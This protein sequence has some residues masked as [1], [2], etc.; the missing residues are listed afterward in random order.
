M[1]VDHLKDL[2][3]IDA[4]LRETLRL[5]PTVPAFSRSI[6]NDNPND[7]EPLLGGQY[8]ARRDDK[9]L[10]LVSKAQRDPKVYGEDAN[11]FRPERM[12]EENFQRLPKAA[13]K[14]FG[15][16]VRACIGRAFA[17]QEAQMAFAL[18]LQSFNFTLDDPSYEMRVKQTLSIKPDGFYMRAALRDGLTAT[19]LQNL[20]TSSSDDVHSAVENGLRRRDTGLG[21]GKPMTILYGSNTDT[22]QALAQKLSVE[23]RRHGYNADVRELNAAVGVLPKDQPIA[24]I[25]ASYEGQ[26]PDNA[27]QFV[28]WLETM[29]AGSNFDGVQ[30]AVFGCGHSDWKSTFQ[31]IPILVDG[32]IEKQGGKRLA[33]R[34][35]TDAA[36]G[37]IFSSFDTWCDHTFWPSF[38]PDT[39]NVQNTGASLEVEMSTLNRSSYLRQ[40]V[41]VGTVLDAR[42][43]TADGEPE[44]RHLNIKLPEGI[45]YETGDYLAILP[46]NPRE[47]VSRAM[48]HFQIPQDATITIKPGAATFLPTGIMISVVDLLRGFVE[49]SLPATKKDLQACVAATKDPAEKAALSIFEE[50]DGFV[51]VLEQ[52]ISLLDLLCKYT[53]V[54]LPF[55]TFVAL[56]YFIFA[57]TR[58]NQVHSNLRHHQRSG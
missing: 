7:V 55:S 38:A 11:E 54:V 5:T 41:Q 37:D 57:I 30:Y 39:Q 20:L 14:P 24:I 31:R 15:N 23:A 42:R 47:T 40:D 46:L 32:L 43:L 1:T 49:L 29:T 18:V 27:D 50:K 28:A 17:W 16:G 35:L 26:P 48:K 34:G 8:A 21:E 12:L 33:E 6:R 25:T 10:C 56:L 44:K 2:K 52:R 36:H 22:C 13:W 9:I 58:S 19:G 3:Y 53:S 51:E 4:V 45:T